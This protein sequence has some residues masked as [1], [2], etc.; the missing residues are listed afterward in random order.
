MFCQ[1]IQQ[2]Y[3]LS[4]SSIVYP[5]IQQS[6]QSTPKRTIF[7]AISTIS[8]NQ[9]RWTSRTIGS[10]W[11]SI[12]SRSRVD[13]QLTHWRIRRFFAFRRRPT[14]AAAPAVSSTTGSALRRQ[15]SV[16]DSCS[17]GVVWPTNA[18]EVWISSFRPTDG[19]AIFFTTKRSSFG[20]RFR[21]LFNFE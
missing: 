17:V 4:N 20:R 9:N 12:G 3:S 14:P 21:T 8:T 16:R 1:S 5:T 7:A 15:H 11:H 13:S 18:A 10:K 6:S 19:V 2:F